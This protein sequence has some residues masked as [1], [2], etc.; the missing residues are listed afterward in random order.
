MKL[1]LWAAIILAVIWILRS[2]K[3][4]AKADNATP[5]RSTEGAAEAMLSCAHCKTYFPASE[6]VFDSSH[7]AFCCVEHRRQHAA[8]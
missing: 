4:A 8:H 1:L 2:K 6:A 3:S 5:P 7:T